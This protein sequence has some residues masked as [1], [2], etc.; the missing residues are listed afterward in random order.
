MAAG[1]EMIHHLNWPYA[2][3]AIIQHEWQTDHLNL[4]LTFN[5]QMRQTTKP[6]DTVWLLYVDT[7]PK[8]VVSSTWQD[9]YTLLL[10]SETLAASPT[11][12]LLAYD[13]PSQNLTTS[14]YKQWEPWGPILSFDLLA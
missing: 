5:Y 3:K 13:G 2:A 11:R 1:S 8:T 4:W 9:A 12:V 10:A 7:V 6:L 14:W